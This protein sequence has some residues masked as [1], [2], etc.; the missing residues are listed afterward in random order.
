MEVTARLL[1]SVL[2]IQGVLL[3]PARRFTQVAAL[4]AVLLF[5]NWIMILSLSLTWR[6][7][8]LLTTKAW[9]RG[10]L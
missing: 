5:Q 10:K 2:R 3:Q 8:F 1:R 6:N 7:V 9:Q 4:F